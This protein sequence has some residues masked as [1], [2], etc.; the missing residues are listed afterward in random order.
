MAS[1]IV[2]EGQGAREHPL[3]DDRTVVGS[4]PRCTIRLH[5]VTATGTRFVLD[6]GQRP[7]RLSVLKGEVLLNDRSVVTAELRHEDTL[8]VG[9]C[10]LRYRDPPTAADAPPRSPAMDEAARTLADLSRL[11]D[12]LG[13]PAGPPRAP[14]SPSPPRPSPRR[15]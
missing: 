8:R 14:S 6:R 11:L 2:D 10:S 5:H 12:S 4:N 7:A 15:P 9:A 3:C 13:R 1:L